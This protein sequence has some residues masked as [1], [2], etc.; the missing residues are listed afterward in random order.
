METE[1]YELTGMLQHWG[2]LP[3]FRLSFP[4]WYQKFKN[5]SPDS[6]MQLL[7]LQQHCH[8]R[9]AIGQSFPALSIQTLQFA[10]KR[11]IVSVMQGLVQEHSKKTS[12]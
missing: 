6:L 5:C 9:K 12:S 2:F 7:P 3:C 4:N 8:E 1:A 10:F 11:L